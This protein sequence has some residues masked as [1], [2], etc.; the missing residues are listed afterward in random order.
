[1]LNS[2]WLAEDLRAVGS[3]QRVDQIRELEVSCF[4]NGDE[5]TLD[6]KI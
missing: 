5:Q 1:M 4:I 2:N 3:N 6:I